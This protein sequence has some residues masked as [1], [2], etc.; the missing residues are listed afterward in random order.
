MYSKKILEV[1]KSKRIEIGDMVR[2]TKGKETYEGILMPRIEL[3]DQNSLTVK[4]ESGYNVGLS[5]DKSAAIKK[6]GKGKKLGVVPKVKIKGSKK[7]PD[8]SIVATGGTIGTHVDYKTGGVFMCR[9]PEEILSTTPE[10]GEIINL[11]NTTRPFTIASEDMTYREWQKIAKMVAKE[12]NS[13]SRGVIVTHGTDIL[14]YSSAA[15]S[16]MLRDLSKP[17]AFVGAQRSPDRGSFDGAMNLICASHFTSHS[18]I[19]E[20]CLVMH[21]STND[22]FCFATRGT[23][24]RKLH[25][26]RR[27]AFQPVNEKPLAKIWRDGGIEKLGPKYRK[28]ED[29]KVT[30]D[31]K[32]EPKTALLKLHPS[33][34][35][36]II[37]WYIDKKYKGLVLEGMGLGHAPTS[38][39]RKEDSWLPWI[40]KAIDKG[41]TLVMTS[42]T[43]FG[44]VNPY[45]YRN[46]RLVSEAGVIYGEDM[47]S[48][49]A[50]VKLS[51]V[52][53]HTR[54]PDKVREMM[55]T[56][57]AGEISQR[58]DLNSVV[59]TE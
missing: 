54:K 48:E 15:A 58:T 38:T 47:L 27:D 42:Q 32:F 2:I 22:D 40:K 37:D 23:R 6:L 50:F 13:G 31:V 45:V 56:S 35:P 28:F 10:I 49:V 46:L 19:G 41:L 43:I 59:K 53:G 8:V 51:W 52:L 29:K 30:A 12:L 55:L 5:F 16:F 14:H 4:L 57:V 34:D 24:V 44:R 21:G 7:L 33:S 26:S 36:S 11:K 3:G 17:V 20:V 25:T 39:I 1:L 18:D 9:S